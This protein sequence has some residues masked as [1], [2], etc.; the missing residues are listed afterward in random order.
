MN[1][2]FGDF[3]FSADTRQ[4]FRA[5]VEVHLS[6]KAFDLLRMLLDARP[7]AVSK[8]VLTERL[9]PATFVSDAN[10]SVL[11]AEIRGALGDRPRNARFVRT[12]QRYGYAF[13]GAA[14]DRRPSPPTA[15]AGEPTCWLVAGATRTPLARGASVIGR[16]PHAEVWL[17]LPGVSRQHARI[18]VGDEDVTIVDLESKNGTYVRGE[19]IA[20]ATRVQNG[21]EI[22]LGP[23]ALTL[24]FP[25]TIDTTETQS[26][27]RTG[28]V[29]GRRQRS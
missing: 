27:D 10:L 8:A 6:P 18:V 4:L 26:P 23:V 13:C 12:V 2:S 1:V 29:D 22:R 16:D 28:P 19:R 9:W 11:M 24:R 17:D 25:S 20:S 21:D 7:K 5:D 14:V 3:T 15:V